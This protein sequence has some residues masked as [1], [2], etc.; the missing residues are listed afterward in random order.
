M[1]W[2]AK[3]LLSEG[4]GLNSSFKEP[5]AK[6]VKQNPG[7]YVARLF[8]GVSCTHLAWIARTAARGA[9]VSDA[10]ANKFLNLLEEA[11]NHLRAADEI[12]PDDPEVCAR[13]IRVYMGLGADREAVQSYFDAAV[14]TEP[15]HLMAHLMMINYLTPK[16]QGSLEEMYEFANGRYNETGNSL[17]VTLLLFAITQEWVYYDMNDETE[18]AASFFSSEELK[19]TVKN[20][21]ADYREQEEGR[22]LIPYVYNYF[23]FLLHQFGEKELTREAVAKINGKMTLYPWAYIG[24]DNSRQLQSIGNGQ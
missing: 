14:Q 3:T 6:W 15:H 9:D 12:Y 24:V 5:I 19:Q 23:A 8:A 2:D 7:S 4:I 22:L 16:W 13:V 18:N 21:Y 17:L 11:S 20:L 1:T 10:N